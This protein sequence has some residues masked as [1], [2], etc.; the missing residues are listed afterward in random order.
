MM[1][2]LNNEEINISLKDNVISITF[3]KIT[4]DNLVPFFIK[5]KQLYDSFSP[6]KTKTLQYIEGKDFDYGGR[7]VF[8]QFIRFLYDN[9]EEIHEI[10][11]REIE[12]IF[13]TQIIY[14]LITGLFLLFPP[15]QKYRVKYERQLEN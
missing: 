4:K 9:F 2:E 11:V 3:V 1:T 13:N 7:E 8:T 5:Y 12:F 15:R 14:L 6:E 10:H